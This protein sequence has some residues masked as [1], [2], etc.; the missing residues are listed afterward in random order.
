MKISAEQLFDL[1]WEMQKGGSFS[2]K[3]VGFLTGNSIVIK[4]KQT[5]NS[6]RKKFAE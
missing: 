1:F 2:K 5:Y 4:I 3:T 6:P